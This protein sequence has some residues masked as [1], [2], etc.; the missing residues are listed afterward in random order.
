MKVFAPLIGSWRYEGPV[1]EDVPGIAKKGAKIVSELTWKWKANK[2]AVER[3]WTAELGGLKFS[4]T[5]LIGW[6]PGENRLVCGGMNSMGGISLGTGVIDM[7]ARTCT[8]TQRGVN[9]EGEPT[10]AEAIT[11]LTGE[12]TITWQATHRE[13]IIVEGPSPVYTYHRVNR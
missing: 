13:G 1:L 6:H 12:D 8:L 11:T 2:N 5:L 7:E 4:S 9:V 3:L 10:S